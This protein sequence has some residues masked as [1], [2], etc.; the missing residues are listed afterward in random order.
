MATYNG[1]HCIQGFDISRNHSF[2]EYRFGIR[3][4]LSDDQSRGY[5]EYFSQLD[6]ELLDVVSKYQ[7]LMYVE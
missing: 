2:D 4:D 7:K 3:F 5:S 6:Q 1:K